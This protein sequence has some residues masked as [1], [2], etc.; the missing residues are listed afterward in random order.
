MR[1]VSSRRTTT[2]PT[3][4]RDPATGPGRALVSAGYVA[5]SWTQLEHG[6]TC[7]TAEATRGH[8][9]YVHAGLGGLRLADPG[10]TTEPR[11]LTEA[12]SRPA[13]LFATAGVPGRS[14]ALD[15]CVAISN[16]AAVRGDASQA[17]FDRNI[18]QYRH[19]IIDLRGQGIVCRPLGL[20]SRRSL[21]PSSHPNPK[22]RSRHRMLPQRTADVGKFPS[23]QMETRNPNSL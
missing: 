4:K 17:A 2:S 22:I 11:G 20:D 13:D 12:Q 9:A 5:H 19:K 8:Y 23:T 18:S 15:V 21:T 14:E 3:C 6:E 10:I 7:S 1:A 16:A